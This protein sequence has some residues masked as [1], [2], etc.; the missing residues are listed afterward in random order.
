MSPPTRERRPG[1]LWAGGA[2]PRQVVRPAPRPEP[3]KPPPPERREGGW[4]KAA[5]GGAV[6]AVLL[7]AGLVIGEAV[8][9]DGPSVSEAPLVSGGSG[10]RTDVGK[11]Y[12]AAGPGVVSVRAGSASGTGFVAD[13]DGTI[14]TN[15]HVVQGAGAARVRFG[16]RGREVSARIMGVDA[17]SDLAALRVDPAAAGKLTALRLADSDSVQVGDDVVAIGH[18]FGLDRT[19]TAGIVSGVGRAIR[20][21]NGFQIDR[22]IQTDAPINP[23]NSGGPLLDS[24]GRVIGVNS[25]IATAGTPGNVGIGFAVPSN[26]VRDVLPRLKRGE[27]VVRPYL[28]MTSGPANGAG[29]R[30]ESVEPGGPAADA[31]L[32]RGDRI[33]SIDGRR[34][35]EPGDVSGS[36]D[37]RRPGD[38]VTVVVERG[39][40]RRPIEVTLGRRPGRTP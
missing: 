21:P 33:V 14:V 31:G 24:R 35:R 13:A 8:D 36:L 4:R 9:S 17:S 23:G 2:P 34:V 10:A 6:A 12:A 38:R 27:R 5:A 32:R 29:A 15:A 25:Q 18:P 16:D 39:G 11:V 28:G 37:G 26:T 20:A 22:V 3:P 19:A 7:A 30:V 40:Q 1:S